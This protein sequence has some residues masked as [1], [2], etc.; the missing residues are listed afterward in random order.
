MPLHLI[1]W[2]PQYEADAH[3]LSQV[4]VWKPQ[5]EED[6]TSSSDQ[7]EFIPSS[8]V[9]TELS[10][11]DSESLAIDNTKGFDLTPSV[12]SEDYHAA[13][14]RKRGRRSK[15]ITPLCTTKVCRS[16]CSN[17][18]TGFKVDLPSDSRGRK[19]LIKPRA[20][21]VISDPAPSSIAEDASSSSSLPPP[22]MTIKHIQEVGTGLCDIPS[23]ELTDEC[24]LAKGED[25]NEQ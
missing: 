2:K 3:H 6:T 20:S 1:V 7:F 10:D 4:I 12:M 5:Y 18:Y 11:D 16:P 19:S 13:P 22:P 8:V 24:L 25:D 9:I 21:I 23:E 17:K 15:S 14:S